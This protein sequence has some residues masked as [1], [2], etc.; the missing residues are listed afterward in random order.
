MEDNRT[1]KAMVKVLGETC[2]I[3]VRKLRTQGI[4]FRNMETIL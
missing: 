2:S 4:R 3:K 1:L